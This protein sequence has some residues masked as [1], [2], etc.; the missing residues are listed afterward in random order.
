MCGLIGQVDSAPLPAGPSAAVERG[1]QALAHRGPD[2]SGLRELSSPGGGCVLGAVRLRILDLSPEGDQPLPNEDESVWVAFNGELY[3]YGELRDELELA[4]HRF[5]SKTDTEVLVHLYEQMAGRPEAMLERLRG[6]FA[7]ALFDSNRGKL[8]LARDRLGIKPL[9]WTETGTGLAFSS[10][11]RALAAAGYVEPDPD[12]EALRGYLARGVVPGLRTIVRGV[13]ELA[14][15][16]FLEWENGR[17][18]IERWWRLDVHPDPDTTRGGAEALGSVLADAV[19]R[20]LVSD[21]PVGVFLSSGVDSSSLVSIA[22][23]MGSVRTFT[24]TFPDDDDEGDLAEAFARRFGA[25]HDPV[26]V[27]GYDIARDFPTI[28]RAMDQPTSDGVNT[29]V[30]CKAAREAGLVVALSGLGGDEWFGGYPSFALVPQASLARSLLGVVPRPLRHA[31]ARAASRRT[32]GGRVARML[33]SEGGYSGAYKAIRGLFAPTEIDGAVSLGKTNGNGARMTDPNDV[34][35]LLE[36]TRYMPDQLLRDTDQMSMSHSLEVR[37][38]LLDDE[39]V[40]T[41]LSVP[42]SV[43]MAAGKEFLARAA[44]L[45]EGRE[46]RPFTLPFHRWVEGPLRGFVEEGLLSEALPFADLVPANLRR[47]LWDTLDSGRVHWSRPW[48]VAVLRL[49]PYVNGFDW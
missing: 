8:L 18:R 46:K 5:R 44:G 39:V 41:A 3:N 22:A 34:V 14:P 21:R 29:W 42:A 19:A 48:A 6:M 20:H 38:P 33:S 49:W 2:A 32:P 25:K 27:T 16:S 10:E 12:P 23:R 17:R 7:F 35:T 1:L 11:V 15:G 40:K 37:V 36:A 47:T 45:D 13:R 26:P 31:A 9:Y 43:R 28:L 30:V 24:V 4:G